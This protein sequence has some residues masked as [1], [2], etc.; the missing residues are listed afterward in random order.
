MPVS[1]SS[2]SSSELTGVL[3][4]DG[5][6]Q[7][8]EL[9]TGRRLTV[10]LEK[11]KIK[12]LRLVGAY[13]DN[14]KTFL[15]P[16]AMRGIRRVRDVYM[17]TPSGSLLIV[18]HT[19][20]TGNKSYNRE[21]SL[22][23][24][25]SVAAYLRDD[26]D[27]WLKNYDDSS[28]D[29]RW[30]QREDS[31]MLA[32]IPTSGPFLEEDGDFEEAVRIFQKKHDLE[33]D[34]ICGPKTRTELVTEY[35]TIDRTTLPEAVEIVVHGCGEDFPAE[36]VG[37]SEA[38]EKNRRVELFV[39]PHTISPAPDKETSKA[40]DTFYPAWLSQIS[41]S[42]DFTDTQPDLL[43]VRLYDHEGNVMP[44]AKFTAFFGKSSSVESGDS[45]IK[46]YAHVSPPAVC[47]EMLHIGWGKKLDDGFHEFHRELFV[48]CFNGS[49][50]SRALTRLYNLGYPAVHDLEF[51]VRA[52]QSDHKVNCDPDPAGLVNGK[53]PEA[54]R[55]EIDKQ[56]EK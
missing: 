33:V 53:I 18:G 23:R 25:K 5:Q 48:D 52:F 3:L 47:P 42:I 29:R 6:V 37:D 39:F 10:R 19:D 50:D 4:S 34:G 1:S 30:G 26:V 24:A 56:F 2:G 14:N 45:D 15:L 28:K 17:E 13:F 46:G 16:A 51:A 44:Q 21:L 43:R 32:T 9:V 12:H 7:I 54:T 38:N 40:G 55:L 41:E 27:T 20:S 49:D 11:S 22:A 35:M 36:D 31:L 8:P